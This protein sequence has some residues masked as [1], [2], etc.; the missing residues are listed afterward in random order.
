M[1]SHL[2][3]SRYVEHPTSQPHGEKEWKEVYDAIQKSLVSS[4]Q[5]VER[6]ASRERISP[7]DSVYIGVTGVW[8]L[9]PVTATITNPFYQVSRS[10][11]TILLLHLHYHS[12]EIY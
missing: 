11:N 8:S 5:S 9:D 7:T 6:D 1:S 10:C 3:I 4:I 12:A 2:R